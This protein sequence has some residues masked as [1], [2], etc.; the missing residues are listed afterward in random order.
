MLRSPQ[1]SANRRAA[2]DPLVAL[3]V[4]LLAVVAT[5]LLIAGILA[6]YDWK[7][8][9]AE[10]PLVLGLAVVAGGLLAVDALALGVRYLRR[11]RL[12]L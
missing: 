12:G 7:T 3:N 5:G 10:T 2:P 6:V 9:G 11:L 1:A 8:P 4:L